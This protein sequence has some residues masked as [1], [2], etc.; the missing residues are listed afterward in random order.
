MRLLYFVVVAAT[1]GQEAVQIAELQ[2]K[3]KNACG[4]YIDASKNN[5][6]SKLIIY[7]IYTKN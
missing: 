7:L 4:S 3:I 2:S 1:A 6:L 5:R